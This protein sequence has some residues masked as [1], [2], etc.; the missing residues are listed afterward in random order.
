MRN[1]MGCCLSILEI[2][3]WLGVSW[4]LYIGCP[5]DNKPLSRPWV[6]GDPD[7]PWKSMTFP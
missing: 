7:I 2:A 5:L 3:L 1:M 6:V 4:S